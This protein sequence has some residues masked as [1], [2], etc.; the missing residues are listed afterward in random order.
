MACLFIGTTFL[1][2]NGSTTINQD[3]WVFCNI[4]AKGYFVILLGRTIF[5]PINLLLGLALVVTLYQYAN[6]TNQSSKYRK[7]NVLSIIAVCAE[8]VFNFIPNLVVFMLIWVFDYEVGNLLSYTG[9]MLA[10]DSIFSALIYR[11]VIT[12][13]IRSTNVVRVQTISSQPV[14]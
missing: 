14:R 9:I 6:S 5:G 7:A 1:L 8:I 12:A 13:H 10:G 11:Y 2:N 4:K 3:C